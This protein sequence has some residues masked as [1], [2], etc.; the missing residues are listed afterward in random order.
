MKL[1]LLALSLMLGTVANAASIEITLSKQPAV[2]A[3]VLFGGHN[4]DI[5]YGWVDSTTVPEVTDVC[6]ALIA[7]QSPQDATPMSKARCIVQ[8]ED[9]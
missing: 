1:L 3:V 4:K 8:I 7:T 5:P 2:M 6:N 9:E